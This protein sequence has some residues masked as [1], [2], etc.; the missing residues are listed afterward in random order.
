MQH[1][2]LH[3]KP[4][5]RYW[6]DLLLVRH[7]QTDWNVEERLMGMRP[8]KLNAEGIAQVE[9]AATLLGAFQPISIYSSPAQRAVQTAQILQER[10]DLQ[11]EIQCHKG[12]GE[13]NM[14][15]WEGRTL[16]EL[17]EMG[18]W[19]QYMEHPEGIVFP[20]GES[21]E[22]IQMRAVTAV[23]EIVQNLSQGGTVLLSSHGGIVRL[24]TLAAYGAALSRYHRTYV[25]NASLTQIRLIPGLAPKVL[26]VNRLP[27]PI[28][29]L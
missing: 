5:A 24:L 16:K 25:S 9:R 26:C 17:R 13:F 3:L 27:N 18:L 22:A 7:G 29:L 28:R 1:Q 15:R 2:T 8:V 10:L 23:N 6:V 11:A 14:G 21:M 4:H 20:G 19:S 12:L